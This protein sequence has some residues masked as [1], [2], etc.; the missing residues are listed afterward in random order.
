MYQTDRV[1]VYQ[2]IEYKVIN[3]LDN[4]LLLVVSITD[5]D[6][7]QYPLQTFIIPDEVIINETNR[8]RDK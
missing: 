6:N 1:A 7:Q 3:V 5:Y 4:D 8:M 2:G